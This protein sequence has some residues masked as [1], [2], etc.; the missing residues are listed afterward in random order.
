[1]PPKG[2]IEVNVLKPHKKNDVL[3]LVRAKVSFREIQRRLGVRR[4][5]VSRYAREAG[6]CEDKINSKP[7]TPLGVATG[8]VVENRPAEATRPP[9]FCEVPPINSKRAHSACAPHRKW[10]EDQVILGRNAMAIYQDLVERF[11]FTHRYNSVKRFV[12]CLKRKAPEVYDVLEFFPG[13]EAQVDYGQGALTLHPKTKRYRRP[14]LFVMTL[15]YSRR[16]FRKVVWESSKVTWARLHEEA[17]RYFGGCP[18]YV[19]LDN[20]KEGVLKPDIFTPLLNATYAAMLAHYE[21]VGDPARVQDPDRKG[22]VEKAIDHTQ[23]TCLKGLKFNSIDEQNERLMNWEER[24]AAKRMHGRA[25]RQ[26][27]EMFQE[28]RPHLK[29]LPLLGFR[30]FDQEERTVWSDTLVE[31]KGSYY[32]A[33]PEFIGQRIPIRIFESTIE[34]LNPVTLEVARRHVRSHRKGKFNIDDK[35]RVFNPCRD[36]YRLFQQADQIGEA[37]GKLARIIFADEGRP[38]QRR[39][40]GLV[41]L[42]R[43]FSREEIERASALVLSRGGRR[44]HFVKRLLQSGG[45]EKPLTET[46]RP[47]TALVQ[48]HELIRDVEDYGA[49]FSQHA[50]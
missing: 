23:S 14:R 20:L 30:Y 35:D 6:L 15:R 8:S 42:V 36:T 3:A 22:T 29:V 31:V 28:E 5:T 45:G 41:T 47:A 25:K 37:T 27:E 2:G 50:K 7:A 48:S 13:E 1:V 21:V 11:G 10:I 18:Q 43:K 24:W 40:M 46:A 49:F 4:E 44:G 17:F 39:V 19:V 34:V 9:A 38:G 12:A 26:V 32:H 33:P 16:S